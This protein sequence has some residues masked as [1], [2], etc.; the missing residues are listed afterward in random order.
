[1]I[2]SDVILEKIAALQGPL[3]EFHP[4]YKEIG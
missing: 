3:P 2:V 1:M 4:G